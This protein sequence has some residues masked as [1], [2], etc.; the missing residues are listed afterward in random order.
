MENSFLHTQKVTILSRLV[1]ESSLTLEE[2][3]LLLKEEEEEETVTLVQNPHWTPGT[4]V[5]PAF[6][7]GYYNYPIVGGSTTNNGSG[8]LFNSTGTTTTPMSNTTSAF[9]TQTD[10][11]YKIKVEDHSAD[12]NT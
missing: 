2:A 5:I 9:V 4:G 8:I 1:K 6:P 11:G 12:L 3:L 7:N 10:G